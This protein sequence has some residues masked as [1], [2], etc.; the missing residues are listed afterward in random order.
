MEDPRS[1]S[2][3]Q[4]AQQQLTAPH[5][6]QFLFPQNVP[7]HS[8]K[9]RRSLCGLYYSQ[10]DLCASHSSAL[11]LILCSIF[12]AAS[13][14]LEGGLSEGVAARRPPPALKVADK[15]ATSKAQPQQQGSKSTHPSPEVLLLRTYFCTPTYWDL[16]G[17]CVTPCTDAAGPFMQ[18]YSILPQQ[19]AAVHFTCKAHCRAIVPLALS[20][21]ALA[22]ILHVAVTAHCG[23]SCGI[24]V[25]HVTPCCIMWQLTVVRHVALC[26]IMWQVDCRAPF[27]AGPFAQKPS[28]QIFTML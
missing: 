23:A 27:T 15:P 20:R 25:H 1:L 6:K 9:E 21:K 7:S 12:E 14:C 18:T 8:N 11:F 2:W 16:G 26:G 13:P 28:L 17:F 5:W 4:I 19:L 3:P 24:M 22:A 10:R